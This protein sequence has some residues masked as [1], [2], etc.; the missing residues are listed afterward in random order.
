LTIGESAGRVAIRHEDNAL[1]ALIQRVKS[2]SWKR[3]TIYDDIIKMEQEGIQKRLDNARRFRRCIDSK[4]STRWR[5]HAT[6]RVS[7]APYLLGA[8]KC[9]LRGYN[10][11]LIKK[12][13]KPFAYMRR[14][15]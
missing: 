3:T 5:W 12:Q 10:P 7:I 9:A 8:F 14:Y 6:T 13:T 11:L 15:L 2:S 4:V 1:S